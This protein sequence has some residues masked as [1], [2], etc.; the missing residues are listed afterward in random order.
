MNLRL[1]EFKVRP[2]KFKDVRSLIYYSFVFDKTSNCF[3]LG[4]S[5]FELA[6]TQVHPKKLN[7]RFRSQTSWNGFDPILIGI[8]RAGGGRMKR[9]RGRSAVIFISSSLLM[10]LQIVSNQCLEVCNQSRNSN[11]HSVVSKSGFST[12]SR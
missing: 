9:R 4:R 7:F 11:L 5:N 6:Q 3:E 1:S 12:L 8:F 10:N 2:A